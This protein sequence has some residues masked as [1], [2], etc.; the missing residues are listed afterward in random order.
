MG[1]SETSGPPIRVAIRFR[2]DQWGVSSIR[3]LTENGSPEDGEVVYV[4][5]YQH[6]AEMERL[7]TRHLEALARIERANLRGRS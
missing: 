6:Y 7:Q 2:P 1:Q 4:L 5:E 3:L